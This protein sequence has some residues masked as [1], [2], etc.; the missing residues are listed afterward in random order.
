MNCLTAIYN[1]LRKIYQTYILP[2]TNL[3]HKEINAKIAI[4]STIVGYNNIYLGENV[5]LGEN[6]VLF[7]PRNKI[8][9]RKNTYSG[10]RLFI[11]TGNH[12]LKKGSFSIFLSDKDKIKDNINNLNWDVTI[13]EDVWIG[14][15][16]SILCKHVGRGAV[17]ACGA[18]CKHD[19]PP[20]S[21]FGGVP[22]RFIKFRF[23]IDEIIEH[24][25]ILY[26]NESRFT[27]EQLENLF[28][29]YKH[30]N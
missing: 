9:I 29:K 27:K 8:I 28:K 22:A 19:I 15:N 4:P 10:P 18:V 5:S 17:I 12:Y 25:S 21:V 3:V 2:N 26:S 16:V 20:Y 23:S 30:E 6:S 24:E 14:A 1:C 7:A 11:S 13:D